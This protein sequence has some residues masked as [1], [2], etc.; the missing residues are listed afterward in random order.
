MKSVDVLAF[1]MAGGNGS[2]LKVLTRDT[3]KPA[4][5]I[6]GRYRI[7]DFVASNIA[8]TGITAMLIATQFEPQSLHKHIGNGE[9]WGFD[10]TDRISEIVNP[11]EE[12]GGMRFEGTADSVRKSI[13]RIYR[14]KPEIVLVLGSDHIYSMDYGEVIKQ[15][16]TS[17][18]DATIMTTAIPDSKASDFGIVKIDESLRITDFS[19]KPTDKKVIEDFRLTARMKE[20]L[21]IR[22]LGLNFL[23]SMGN[24]V[25][26]WERL[27][28]FLELPGEDFG[29]DIIPAIKENSGKLYAYIFNGYWRDVGGI[30]DYFDCN[31]DFTDGSPPIGLSDH[32]NIRTPWKQFPRARVSSGSSIRNAIIGPCD[33]IRSRTEI[34]NSILGPGITVEQGCS[35][36]QCVLL[37]ANELHVGSINEGGHLV[38]IGENTSL[39]HVILDEN[40]CIGNNVDIG[41]RNGS[42]ER[43]EQILQ[44]I[45][46]K[47]YRDYGNGKPE[48][49]FYLEPDT[50]IL[51]IGKP[52]GANYEEPIL[53]DG[54]KC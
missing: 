39:S 52:R 54:L 53:P 42:A 11:H 34:K 31:M 7:F 20:R 48:G 26:Y 46:L 23:A 37:G 44:G 21:G 3:C 27:K 41:P 36:D 12:V 16:K 19:E 22:D 50:G 43:R 49:D 6:L 25:F 13:Y 32:N 28:R 33:I 30:Q 8:R 9:A 51:V 38:R 45:G 1:V 40:V 17:N 18:A 2:R 4:V 15:H 29:K 24:Y 14:Y 10:G 47:P 5:S 35:L